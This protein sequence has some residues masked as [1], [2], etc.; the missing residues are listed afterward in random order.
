[1]MMGAEASNIAAFS[2]TAPQIV[3]GGA[4]VFVTNVEQF[5]KY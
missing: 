5:E 2:Y 3:V 1:M 4:T